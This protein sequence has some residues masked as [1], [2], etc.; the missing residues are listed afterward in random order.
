[1]T[2]TR[3]RVPQCVDIEFADP[4]EVAEVNE[5]NCFNS[6]FLSFHLVFSTAA[7]SGAAP[8]FSFFSS[9]SIP[10][11]HLLVIVPLI[12]LGLVGLLN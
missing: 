7:L 6:T 9:S 10:S 3:S 5:E 12:V 2:L 8:L 4:S 11:I 1:M